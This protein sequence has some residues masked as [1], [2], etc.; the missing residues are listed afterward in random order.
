MSA[1]L[2][3]QRDEER[4]PILVVEVHRAVMAIQGVADLALQS[5]ARCHFAVEHEIDNDEASESDRVAHIV[6]ARAFCGDAGSPVD[7]AER[8]ANLDM[9]E[10]ARAAGQIIVEVQSRRAIARIED[11]CPHVETPS[12]QRCIEVAFETAN[13]SVVQIVGRGDAGVI[14]DE[15]IDIALKR[16]QR[17]REGNRTP[18]QPEFI[19]MGRFR[20][21]LGIA[22][23]WEIQIVEGRSTECLPPRGADRPSIVE[24]PFPAYT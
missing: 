11:R 17:D 9:P 2:I 3:T 13:A 20:I 14:D 10:S 24:Q 15:I 1:R 7:A 4:T 12:T 6:V 16:R 18:A 21:E 5:P 8:A 19:A 23:T 22:E